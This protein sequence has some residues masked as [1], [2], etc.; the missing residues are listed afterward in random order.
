MVFVIATVPS[1]PLALC[2]CAGLKVQKAQEFI[3]YQEMAVM[4]MMNEYNHNKSAD[5]DE[6]DDNGDH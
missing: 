2:N 3:L 5:D 4:L 6:Y 1:F